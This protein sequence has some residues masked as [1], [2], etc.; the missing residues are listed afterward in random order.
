M[1]KYPCLVLDHDDTVVQSME[2]SYDFFL[3][4]LEQ[5]RPGTHFSLEAYILDCHNLGF[6][7]MCRQRFGFTDAELKNEHSQWMAYLQTHVPDSY[8]GIENVIR[9]QKEEG[10]LLCVV[11]H[12]SYENISRD[13]RVHF[14]FQPDAI[15][16]ADLPAHQRKPSSWP[17]EDIMQR[18]H[19]KPSDILVVDDMKLAWQ[20]AKPLNVPIAFA[21]WSKA[22]F[23]DL[24][25]EMRNICDF[26]FE[27]TENLERFLFD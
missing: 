3:Y 11:S 2:M 8:P 13:Y 5:F 21:G 19:L 27:T 9:R 1:L 14:G 18:Y 20:M 6:V 17:L 10:G 15:Y 26:S 12:S 24:A 22:D 4:I 16:G 7:G 25:E 23:P